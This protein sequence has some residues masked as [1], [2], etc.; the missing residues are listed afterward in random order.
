MLAGMDI[1]EVGA[2]GAIG[3]RGGRM[4]KCGVR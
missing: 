1:G 3:A 2:I 4:F